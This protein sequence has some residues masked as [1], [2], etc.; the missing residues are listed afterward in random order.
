MV[1]YNLFGGILLIIMNRIISIIYV[2]F[3]IALIVILDTM[4][5]LKNEFTAR[6]IVNVVIVAIFVIVYVILARK[7]QNSNEN[8]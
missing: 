7:F 4:T 3:F 1:V 6:L 5:Y 8:M 2:I